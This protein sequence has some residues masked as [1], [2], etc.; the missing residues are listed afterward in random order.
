MDEWN[1]EQG[2]K[3][4]CFRFVSP[5]ACGSTLNSRHELKS[6]Q[7]CFFLKGD[8]VVQNSRKSG[9]LIACW[10]LIQ[11][12]TLSACVVWTLLGFERVWKLTW[13]TSVQNLSFISSVTKSREVGETES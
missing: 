2:G 8:P 4:R 11:C 6:V 12:W 10:K 7:Q 3:F 9:D 13:G 5:T 1:F